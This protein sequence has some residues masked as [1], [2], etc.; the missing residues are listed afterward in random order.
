MV[1]LLSFADNAAYWETRHQQEG[2]LR[3]GGH[4]SYDEA[5]NRMF[6]LRRLSMLLELI[7][8]HCDPVAPLFVLD[9]G[10]GKGWFSRELAAVGHQVDGIDASDTALAHCRA[11][12]GGPH[13]HRS[14]LSSWRSPW[15]Y[16]VAV[17]VDVLFHVLDD[18]EWERSV[19]NL[20][21]LV[22][23]GGRLIVADWGEEHDQ[24]YGNYQVVRGR[25]RYLPL[26]DRCGMRFDGWHPYRFRGSPIGFYA[27]TRTR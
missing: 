10:C 13:F 25:Q 18:D 14:T 27:F 1:G 22:R 26:M 5:T 2:D 7:G 16:D 23:L 19:R 4:V 17:C 20:A 8:Q 11:L 24:V 6:Y 21:S 15:L 12:G 3:S 9:A